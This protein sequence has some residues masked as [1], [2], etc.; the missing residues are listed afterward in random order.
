MDRAES[1]WTGADVLACYAAAYRRE[2][3]REDD[4]LFGAEARRKS[5]AILTPLLA[6]FEGRESPRAF[7][8]W[9]VGHCLRGRGYPSDR[10]PSVSAL[11][12]QWLLLKQWR[13]RQTTARRR[14]AAD[15]RGRDW[16]DG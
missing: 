12:Y 6:R 11:V 14:S 1:D 2:T 3:G 13:L 4:A 9:A 5:A 8:E 7:V 10:T 16:E 15:T